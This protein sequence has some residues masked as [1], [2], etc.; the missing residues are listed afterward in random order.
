MLKILQA[1]LQH[2]MWAKNFQILKLDLE[3]AE[4]TYIK[5]PIPVGSQKKQN[6]SKKYLFLPIDHS[7]PFE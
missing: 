3:K 5:L 1:K 7:K 4:G 6:S 2:S